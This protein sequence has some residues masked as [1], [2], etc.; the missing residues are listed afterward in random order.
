MTEAGEISNGSGA[1]DEV[2]VASRTPVGSK[3]T[4]DWARTPLGSMDT[5]VPSLRTVVDLVLASPLPMI[6]LWGPERMQIYNEGYR[7]AVGSRRTGEL[8]ESREQYWSEVWGLE[9]VLSDRV[10]EAGES[11]ILPTLELVPDVGRGDVT[12]FDLAISRVPG[13]GRR[14]GGI[15]VTLIDSTAKVSA[16]ESGE[17][18]A[19][20]G[21]ELASERVRRSLAIEASRLGDWELDLRT[22]DSPRRST[23]HDQIFGYSSP[24]PD[25][26]FE[27]FLEHVHPHD[28]QMVRQAFERSIEIGRAWEFEC[29][30]VGADGERRWIWARG[31]VQRDSGG[32]PIR[33]FGVVAD[34][35]ERKESEQV[36]RQYAEQLRGLAAAALSIHAIRDL[37]ELMRVITD[38]AR[39]LI[40]AHQAI[41]CVAPLSKGGDPLVT[42]SLSDKY[43]S[44]REGDWVTES[45]MMQ[46]GG[47]GIDQPVRLGEEEMTS[48]P[49]WQEVLGLS[50]R[51]PPMRGLLGVP[52]TDSDDRVFGSIRLSD[53]YDGD[54]SER[55]ESVL[56]QLGHL[57]AVAIENV[58]LIEEAERANRVKAEFLAAMS[59]ELR[60]PLNAVGGYVDI[61]D[62]GVYGPLTEDQKTAL[63][64]IS[65]NQKYLLTLI[66]DILS[67]A[68]LEAGRLEFDLRSISARE[69][70]ESMDA[71]VAQQT[72]AK[73][74]SFTV[75]ECD[76][77]IHLKGDAERV[78][79]I[80]LNLASN[81]IKF[82]PAGGQVTLSCEF[83]ESSV[84]FQVHDSGV[85][86]PPE[87]Q[88]QIFEAFVQVDRRL[89]HPQEGVGLGLAISRDLALAMEGDLQ[90]HST[91]GEG[92]T[93]TLRL[94]RV[95]ADGG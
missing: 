9:D 53:G 86:I 74:V 73:G 31:D 22:Q 32:E 72:R 1:E 58:H 38:R 6:V 12:V 13:E 11:L 54:F 64:R 26:S 25:W 66:D 17:E 81:A 69:V 84:H 10:S 27:I 30:I 83:D 75:R 49:D 61:L 42:G 92:S 47:L 19:R 39:T 8:G 88:E 36:L 3:P 87:R 90:V 2:T 63:S 59:H 68:R 65:A 24:R 77:T 48:H 89:D 91:V 78:R 52:L 62:L 44:Y 55:D 95:A 80:L 28:R 20:L 50:G 85:G 43:A 37:R 57:A 94:P 14:A 82:T 29:R 34:V 45:G 76:P 35:T 21:A 67:F 15:L 7:A 23:R 51:S 71:L 18:R 56:I 70:L 46:G 60:T 33:M 93:F 41:T 16:R 79:Q 5:W 40:G 4:I